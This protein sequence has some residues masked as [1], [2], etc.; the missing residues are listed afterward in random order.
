MV[1]ILNK[2]L[3]RN[4]DNIILSHYFMEVKTHR[5]YIILTYNRFS[6]LNVYPFGSKYFK[7]VC[8]LLPCIQYVIHVCTLIICIMLKNVRDRYYKKSI[9]RYAIWALTKNIFLLKS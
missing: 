1:H 9:N 5:K 2:H 3:M 8:F 4:C 6:G 7:N